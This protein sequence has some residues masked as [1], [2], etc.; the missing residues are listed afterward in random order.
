M[1]SLLRV[2]LCGTVVCLSSGA[3]AQTPAE[4]FKEM[5]SRK[6][7]SLKNVDN[8][9]EMKTVM[10]MCTLEYFEKDS[11]ASEDGRGTVEYLRLV[12][13]TEVL[14]RRSPDSAMSQASPADL[15]EAARQLRAKGPEIDRAVES[16]MS[17]V[18]LPGDLSSMLMN[19]PPD[20]PW[21]SPK[22][23][24]MMS[25]YA[26]MLEGAANGKRQNARNAA[27]AEIE[28]QTDPLAAVADRTRLVGRE[29]IIDRPAFH[30][31]AENLDYTQ[32]ADGSE[33]KLDTLHLWVDTE[34]YV[35]LKMQME[36]TAS[37]GGQ[38]R[39]LRIE[40]EN[41]AYRQVD[42]CGTMYEPQRSVM[43]IAGIL[44]PKEQA[45]MQKAQQ[46]LAQMESQL[47]N[48][49]Q[50]QRD[51]IMRQMGPQME[52]FKNMAAGNGIEVVSLTVGMRCNAE[53]PKVQEYIQTVPGISQAACVGFAD[54]Q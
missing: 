14:E 52:M 8:V 20:Q 42:G 4:I 44:G 9:S 26:L 31:V 10:G 36:G 23:G 6:R 48:L 50:A 18:G 54:G 19:P 51:M 17:K 3:I 16:E 33:F 2:A 39:P 28:A 24:D 12:P 37:Q 5:D 35:P 45:D 47:A 46:Q 1:R 41:T 13:L 27:A 25:N 21:L 22:P 32:V 40:R 38:S 15:D 43:R 29:T 49:P 30:L 7:A 11:T 34:H 53:L